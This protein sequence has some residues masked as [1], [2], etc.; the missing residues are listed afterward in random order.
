MLD[1]FRG[2]KKWEN[3]FEFLGIDIHSHLIPGIDDG[4]D[5][6]DTSLQL[7]RS[8]KDLGFKHLVATP[9]IMSDLYPNTRNNILEGLSRL[10]K[11][12][13][14][15]SID[16][17]IEAAAEYYMDENFEH[18]IQNDELLT[19]PHNR[20]LVEMSFVTAP[21]NLF[22]YIFKLQ[23][24]GYKPVLAHPERYL[25]LKN[26]FSEYHRLKEYGCEFQLNILSLMGYYGK[27][28]QDTAFKLLKN[29][30][31]DY[32]GTDLHHHRHAEL[33]R[34]TLLDRK[35]REIFTTY[36]FANAKLAEN[37]VVTK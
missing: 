30:L 32:L 35:A 19:L 11:A 17:K 22:H 8:L 9:H 31:V 13:E 33:L 18:I 20:V 16:I 15:A 26:R 28:I 34:E 7:I 6:M 36:E 29:K 25:F 23:T 12:V 21:P 27:S 14:E 10:T 4:A 2:K 24:K 5:T 1:F 37:V 3:N